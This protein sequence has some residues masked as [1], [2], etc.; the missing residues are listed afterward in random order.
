MCRLS[1]TIFALAALA[2]PLSAQTTPPDSP[3]KTILVLDASG[4]MWGQIDG[5]AK[6][7][8]AKEVISNL[9][10]SLPDTTQLGLS[11]YGHRQKGQCSDIE[12]LVEPGAGTREAIRSAV[13]AINPKGKTPL[14]QAVIDAAETL[15][16]EEDVATVI[17][18]SDGVETCDLD[19]CAVGRQLEQTGIG[20]TAH[21][22]GFDVTAEQDIAQLACLA[23]E[24][25]GR[26]LS[27]ANATELSEAL[28]QVAEQ[29]PP[30]PAKTDAS[31]I[32][33]D[34]EG[35][36]TITSGI[37]WTLAPEAADG[38]SLEEFDIGQ[39]R[40]AMTPGKYTA[41]VDRPATEDSVNLTVTVTADRP[42]DFTLA[43]PPSIPD[44]TIS[45][46]ATA[47]LGSSIP[48]TWDGPAED[49]DYLTVAEPDAA[50][51]SYINYASVGDGS[52]ATLLLP[53]KAGTYELRYYHSASNKVIASVPIEVTPVEITLSAPKSANVAE[54]IAVE[55]TGPDYQ[56][57]YIDIAAEADAGY[58]TYAYTG[59]G[60]PL[61][62]TMPAEP[63]DY[64]IRY[65]LAQDATVL[66]TLP[67]TVTDVSATIEAPESAEVGSTI[68]VIWEGPD[69]DR[70][71][72]SI[73]VPDSQDS[74]YNG[75][76]YT[77]DGSPLKLVL[78]SEP[79]EYE[80]RYVQAVGP[81]VIARKPI[82]VVPTTATITALEEAAAG[83]TITVEW[84]GPDN[85]R[86]YISI[87]EAGADEG[88]YE[89]Y[90]YTSEG[91]P[92]KLSMPA[93]PGDYELRYV[94]AKGNA[95]VATR[96][97]TLVASNASLDG[98]EEAE[99]G[100]SITVT[101]E[102]PDNARDYISIAET[103]A[104]EGRYEK[105]TYTSDGSPLKLALPPE[106]GDYE[107][108]YVLATGNK[109]LVSRPI[110]LVASAASVSGPAEAE[111]GSLITVTWEGPDNARDYIS[112]AEAGAADG[113]YAKYT[114]TSDGS[115]LKLQM[116]SDP[117]DYELRYV[118]AQGNKT[119]ATQPITLVGATASVD[120][121]S[122]A[123]AGS[124]IVVTWEGP[125]NARD[126]IS[127][128]ESGADEGRYEKYTYTSDGTPLRLQMPSDAGAYEI[129]YVL[130][131][132]NK[133]L[134]AMPIT[135]TE[136]AASL[137]APGSVGSGGNIAV[138]WQG[139]DNKRDYISITVPDADDNRYE[140]YVYTSD[141]SPLIIKAPDAPGTYELRYV[142]GEGPRV[143]SRREIIVE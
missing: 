40:L 102:G 133:T 3:Q 99:A 105:Y 56:N 103:G 79:G 10:D 29:A 39:L 137:D 24:T 48:V 37:L 42:N 110:T 73:A 104:D 6:I 50:P 111:A 74:H 77:S 76:T 132:G 30:P 65:V 53:P 98:P 57:D 9:L 81:R 32:A 100:G 72:I 90:T 17:L 141:G 95:T 15:K 130:A 4:S 63:G 70:D 119:I 54:I 97:I 28:A 127:I 46:P 58:E 120:A 88:R 33:T 142:L 122:E 8:I 51:Q 101:W 68:A 94:L 14:S 92:L 13:N 59:E 67:I 128:A 61:K 66:A 31:F 26:F 91:S 45:G 22:V 75:Y 64:V 55:W 2:L 36:P 84:T 80:L 114:Y 134:V 107:L 112:I 1:A 86:D 21:V 136:P 41:T 106:P 140:R 124:V 60:S 115:P 135:I 108:R 20:F 125:D 93:E 18:V 44:A 117:G 69:N 71:Y 5:T 82:N 109:T 62:L 12:L 131:T 19:P 43:L 129:R 47:P 25:G 138:T 123:E 96:P 11:A 85:A 87:A 35:G 121:P 139:P 34:G 83:S 78:P 143:I 49:S 89:K 113:R 27:A 118:L 16:Y 23:E 52:P 116:P 7:T 126:Y 38:T